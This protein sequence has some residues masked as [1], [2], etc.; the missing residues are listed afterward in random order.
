MPVLVSHSYSSLLLGFPGLFT[1]KSLFMQKIKPKTHMHREAYQG[2]W[3]CTNVHQTSLI[4]N[5]IIVGRRQ[6]AIPVDFHPTEPP[7]VVL[8]RPQ[9]ECR[10]NGL[11]FAVLTI[12]T[13]VHFFKFPF[14]VEKERRKDGLPLEDRY[15]FFFSLFSVRTA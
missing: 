14:Q 4:K 6:F 8:S 11:L 13:K 5:I 9:C 12:L 1:V 3:W 10:I 7:D 2:S 15:G